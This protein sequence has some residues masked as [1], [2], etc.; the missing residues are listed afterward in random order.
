MRALLD[1][2]TRLTQWL[3]VADARRARTG[4]VE[5]APPRALEAAAAGE[6]ARRRRDKPRRRGV[7]ARLR[8]LFGGGRARVEPAPRLAGDDGAPPPRDEA[9][10]P[11]RATGARRGNALCSIAPVGRRAGRPLG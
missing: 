5:L 6:R 3:C 9:R 1:D 2:L 10:A 4:A 11:A 7:L 8:G